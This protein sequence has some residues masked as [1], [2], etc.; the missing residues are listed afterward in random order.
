MYSYS[1]KCKQLQAEGSIDRLP[2]KKLCNEEGE[3]KLNNQ[4]HE[5]SLQGCECT[6]A[7]VSRSTVIIVTI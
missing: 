3:N 2:Q 4:N 1:F 7:E 5:L 6:G